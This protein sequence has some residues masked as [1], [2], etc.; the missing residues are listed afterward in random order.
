M[1][2]TITGRHLEVTPAMREYVTTKLQRITRHFDQLVDTRVTLS[3][4]N[5]KD[6]DRRQH[7]ECSIRVKGNDI[8]AESS[9]HDMYAAIDDLMDKLDRQIVRHK[10]KLQTHQLTEAQKRSMIEQA[11]Q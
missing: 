10:D 2:L 3:I 8:H 5:D 9:Q 4:L 11:Q 7:A 1:N 6:K